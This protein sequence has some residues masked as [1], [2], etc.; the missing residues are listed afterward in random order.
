[1]NAYVS[2]AP[3]LR[4]GATLQFLDGAG[5]LFLTGRQQLFSLNTTAAFIWC[6]LEDGLPPERIAGRLND[7]FGLGLEDAA[8]CV[9]HVLQQWSDLGLLDED[10]FGIGAASAPAAYALLGT[11]FRLQVGLPDLLDL[12]TPLLA[13]LR[14]AVPPTEP[15]TLHLAVT[16]DGF[17]LRLADRVIESCDLRRQVVPMIK[18]GL[19]QLALERSRDFCALH[20]AAVSLNG[21]ALL[22]PG[23]SGQGKSTLAAALAAAGLP[24]FGDDTVVLSRDGLLARPAPFAICLKSGSWPL[25]RGRFPDLDRLPVHHRLDGKLVRYVTPPD[26]ERWL[27]DDCRQ[28]VAWIVFPCLA[29]DGATELVPLARP[30]AL[31]RL[32]AEC[33]P[34]DGGLDTAKVAR[35]VD[36]MRGIDC[37][38]LR[39]DALDDAIACLQQL[40]GS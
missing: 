24:L 10:G 29:P 2:E 40:G 26:A 35:L 19:I 20:A 18:T 25:L 9:T 17:E 16:P 4:P 11:H 27:G 34:L 32:L 13:P 22:L 12:L 37:Y 31:R 15:V 30:E 14:L 5:M 21:R 1:M 36:W 8:K 7:T 6:L 28:T 23:A 39:I 3:R 33:F 38:E